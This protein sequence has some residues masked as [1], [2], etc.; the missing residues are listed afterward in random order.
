MRRVFQRNNQHLP[1]KSVTQ[2]MRICLIILLIISVQSLYSQGNI[3]NITF[4]PT[5]DNAVLEV[6]KK[7]QLEGEN[8]EI[9]VLKFYVSNIKFY[10]DQQQVGVFNN[11][12]YLIDLENP[13]TLKLNHQNNGAFNTIDFDLGIDSTT[14]V[15]GALGGDLDPTNGMYWT[16]QS[17]YI[18]FKLEGKSKHCPTRNNLFSFHIGGYQYPFNTLQHIRLAVENTQKIN[19]EVDI[20]TLL[21][22]INLTQTCEVM[23]PNQRAMSISKIITSIF[24]TSQ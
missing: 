8:T 23:S 1:S 22:K 17:G 12:H 7:Y 16:W 11:K 3:I 4:N 13:E 20:S 10:Q 15:S 24:K 18:N 9:H 19:I 6:D 14:N 5:F 21:K 2:K